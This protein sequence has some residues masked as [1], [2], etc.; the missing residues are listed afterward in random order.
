MLVCWFGAVAQTHISGNITDANKDPMPYANVYIDGSYD[1]TSSDIDGNFAFDTYE[2]GEQVLVVSV[3]GYDDFK[4]TINLTGESITINPKMGISVA[5]LE[6]VVITAGA[7][8]A[9]DAKKAVVLRPLDIVTTAGAN[10]D[11]YGAI[12][13]LPGTQQV[14]EQEGLFVRGGAAGET[15]TIIDE[16][17]VRDPFFSS[18]PNIPQRGRFSPFLFDG[19]VFS[20]GG[21][22]AVYGQA[23]SSVLVLNTQGLA[24]DTYTGIGIMPIGGSI[25]HV[26]AWDKTSFS[27]E[28]SYTHLGPYFKVNKQLADWNDEPQGYDGSIGFRQ[29]T[30]ETGLYKFYGT[31]SNSHLSL[32]TPDLDDPNTKY[33][34]G[35]DNQNIYLNSSWKE[36]IGDKWSVFIGSSYAQNRDNITLDSIKVDEDDLLLQGKVIFSRSMGENSMLK[37]GA[38]VKDQNVEGTYDTLP[39]NIEDLYFAGFA[40]T[41][42]YLTYKLAARVGVRAEH[43]GILGEFNIA[44]RTSLAY[45]TG[46]NSQ[47]SVAYGQFYQNPEDQFLFYPSALTYERASHYIANYQW[48]D[49]KRTFRIEFYDKEYDQLVKNTTTDPFIGN[50]GYGYARGFDVFYRDKETVPNSDFWISY[51]Y[52]DTKRNF[53]DYPIEAMPHYASAHTVSVVYKYWISAITTSISA[54]YSYGSGRPYYNPNNAPQDFHSNLTPEYHNLDISGS[55]LTQIKDNFTVVFFSVNNVLNRENTFGYQ[56]DSN[57]QPTPVRPPSLRTFFVGVFISIGT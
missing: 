18:V 23:L 8:E 19:V 31:Y 3:I 13:T 48:M 54:T 20:T 7:F 40:E 1:G 17:Y 14:G 37:F 46:K 53:R 42:I 43:S 10:G 36:V 28:G 41:D 32:F 21:Y 2:T 22:S 50:D 38:D 9:S 35:L 52:L 49:D 6:P 30:S 16:M 15:A 29:K 12:Q 34:F 5:E 44:P 25:S 27:I 51:S 56:F 39:Y 24:D 26:H 45:K 11:I 57:G 4:E 33:L 55:Y 47:I